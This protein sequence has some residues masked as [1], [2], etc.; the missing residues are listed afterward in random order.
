MSYEANNKITT[1]KP[2]S[3]INQPSLQTLQLCINILMK[4]ENPIIEFEANAMSGCKLK[5]L[6]IFGHCIKI[7]DINFIFKYLTMCKDKKTGTLMT[8]ISK[9][10]LIHVLIRNVC[11]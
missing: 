9:L 10:I 4:V 7:Q 3:K 8:K 1:L 6:D 2:L 11:M 5:C